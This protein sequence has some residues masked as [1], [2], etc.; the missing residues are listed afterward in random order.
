MLYLPSD[1][2]QVL[3][4]VTHLHI[5][6]ARTYLFRFDS[7]KFVLFDNTEWIWKKFVHKFYHRVE[8]FFQT[9]DDYCVKMITFSQREYFDS[10]IGDKNKRGRRFALVYDRTKCKTSPFPF[11]IKKLR[12]RLR[13]TIRENEKRPRRSKFRSRDAIF[14]LNTTLKLKVSGI[15]MKTSS[16]QTLPRKNRISN[17][18]SWTR[19]L[20]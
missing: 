18:N 7:S 11:W 16:M 19:C 8:R 9:S 15:E 6:P 5:C 17:E 3:T 1:I 20:L 12:F 14:L 10:K 13:S 4:I 2:L